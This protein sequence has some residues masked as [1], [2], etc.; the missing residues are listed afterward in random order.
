ML[1]PF[2]VIHLYK[3]HGVAGWLKKNNQNPFALFKCYAHTLS[4]LS[5]LLV[6]QFP[7]RVESPSNKPSAFE[8]RKRK[9]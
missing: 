1:S 9:T 7:D 3:I 5:P 2:L 4:V 8:Q 6:N